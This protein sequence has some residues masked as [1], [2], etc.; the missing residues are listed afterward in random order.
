VKHKC[1][2]C[3]NEC[4]THEKAETFSD[5]FWG[6]VLSITDHYSVSNCCFADIWEIT[7]DEE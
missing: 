3:G 4:E 5:E 2:E 6:S 1:E 7:T